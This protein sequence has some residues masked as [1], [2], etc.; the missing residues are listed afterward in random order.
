MSILS[1]ESSV[2]WKYECWRDVRTC[3]VHSA[4]EHEGVVWI[5]LSGSYFGFQSVR[6]EAVV[7]STPP[8][9]GS[10]IFGSGGITP[11]FLKV[12]TVLILM[13]SSGNPVTY[14]TVC[15]RAGL[16]QWPLK[17]GRWGLAEIYIMRRYTVPL[18]P[19]IQIWIG[20]WFGHP[21]GNRTWIFWSIDDKSSWSKRVRYSGTQRSRVW[22]RSI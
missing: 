9:S 12:Y 10:S 6:Y 2:T 1:M 16:N 17:I 14:W 22:V 21:A 13:N 8:K 4:Y 18:W 3:T 7:G 11:R 19:E 20:Q 15:F 5:C